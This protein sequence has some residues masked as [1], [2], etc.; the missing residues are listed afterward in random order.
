M[1]YVKQYLLRLEES[2][3]DEQ[4]GQDAVRWAV[5][6]GMIKL[7]GKTQYDQNTIA[8]QYDLICDSFRHRNRATDEHHH[9]QITN[10]PCPADQWR[11]IRSGPAKTRQMAVR[12]EDQR[13]ASDGARADRDLL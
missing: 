7:T 5:E 4:F 3:S 11:A 8:A 13:V 2:A 1:G 12:T 10:L 9:T 6:S